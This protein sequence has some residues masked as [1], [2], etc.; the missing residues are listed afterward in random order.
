MSPVTAP[1]ARAAIAAALL[2]ACSSTSTNPVSPPVT[3]SIVGVSPAGGATN[4]AVGAVVT[5]RFD[6]AMMPGMQQF[7]ALHRDSLRGPVVD[8]TFAWADDHMQLTFTPSAPLASHTTYVIHVGGGMTDSTGAPIDY[9]RCP[10][11]GGQNV[12]GNMMSGGGMMGG[13]GGEMGPGWQG[14]NGMYGMEFVFTTT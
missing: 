10:G 7:V 1:L 2:T 8:G 9:G 11:L 4:V 14:P 3:T 12:T 13:G 6:H 5:L